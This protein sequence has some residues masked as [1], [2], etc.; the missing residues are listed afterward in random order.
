MINLRPGHERGHTKLDWLDSRHT[1][2]F[3][4]YYDP[5]HM[6]FGHLRVIN[7]DRVQPGAGFGMHGHRDMEILTYVLEGGLQHHDSMRNGSIIR[8]GEVQRMSAG[9]GI[10]HSE[11]NAS[12]AEPV[13][14][15][16]IW[17]LPERKGLA[18]GYEQKAIPSDA[19][20][21]RWR[22]IAA[23]DGRE[24]AV[25]VQQNVDLYTA[26]PAAG[27]TAEYKLASGHQA[28]LQVARGAVTLNGHSLKAGDGAAVQE[29]SLDLKAL[30]PSELLLF[31]MF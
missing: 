8:P 7:E 27:E 5:R 29:A 3:D 30:E 19:S 4:Q 26:R 11:H 24:G 17:L 16:Q 25:T 2:S 15:Y 13:H 9:T 28:W 31:D 20:R 21:G 14:F 22:L 18:P 10:R 23:R 1:F 6:G 12:Q